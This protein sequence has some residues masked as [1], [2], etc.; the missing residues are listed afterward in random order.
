[1]IWAPSEAAAFVRGRP[2]AS[3]CSTSKDQCYTGHVPTTRPRHFVTETDELADAL[4]EA[5]AGGPT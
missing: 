3:G 5:G 1:M 4:N 2:D